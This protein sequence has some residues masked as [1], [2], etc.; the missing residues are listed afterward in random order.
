[1]QL[2]RFVASSLLVALI[3]IGLIGC[4]GAP[5]ESQPKTEPMK[6]G[7]PNAKKAGQ[8]PAPEAPP[9]IKPID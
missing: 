7:G 6:M 3:V 4:G 5:S 2:S 1:M 9:P 8:R